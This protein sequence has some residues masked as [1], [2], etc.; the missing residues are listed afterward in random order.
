M[1]VFPTS[2]AVVVPGRPVITDFN[3]CE[4][5]LWICDISELCVQLLQPIPQP[6]AAGQEM[7]VGVFF[8]LPETP[9]N[10]EFLG[11]LTNNRPTDI[12]ST[13]WALNP[14]VARQPS[15][16]I[17]LHWETRQ[18]LEVKLATRPPVDA[19]KEMAKKVALNLFRYVES[20]FNSVQQEGLSQDQVQR[21]GQILQGLLDKWFRR[22][23]DR[24]AIDPLFFIR[25][26]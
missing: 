7:G 22:F 18:S 12:F 14:D 26:E 19:K 23:E 25:T 10:W 20:F 16:R 9:G 24:Y 6:D 21:V 1:S 2:L 4:P 17:G 15:I 3:N 8:S 11:V 5:G 13:G